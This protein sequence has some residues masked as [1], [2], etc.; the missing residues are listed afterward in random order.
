MSIVYLTLNQFLDFASFEFYCVIRISVL[1]ILKSSKYANPEAKEGH[2]DTDTSAAVRP[3]E[4]TQPPRP[5]GVHASAAHS[6]RSGQRQTPVLCTGPIQSRGICS[7]R[8]PARFLTGSRLFAPAAR[9]TGKCRLMALHEH[10]PDPVQKQKSEK[11]ICR[12]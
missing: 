9:W 8:A 2:S 1:R 3:A 11:S 4:R 5:A 10:R 12:E 6:R 7:P